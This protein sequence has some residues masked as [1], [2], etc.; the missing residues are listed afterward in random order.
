MSREP[1]HIRGL[2]L[3]GSGLAFLGDRINSIRQGY[4]DNGPVFT[5]SLGPKKLAVVIG[6]ELATEYFSKPGDVLSMSLATKAMWPVM[7]EI[8]FSDDRASHR[9]LLDAYMPLVSKSV[10]DQH[11]SVMIEEVNRSL[12]SFGDTG[13]FELV[14]ISERLS[15]AITIRCFLGDQFAQEAGERFREAFTDLINGIDM[16]LPPFLPLPKFRRRDRAR[17]YIDALI[18]GVVQR[19]RTMADPPADAMQW[20]ST[21]RE[22][23]GEFW[24]I[25]DTVDVIVSLL[26]G[27]HHITGALMSWALV[28][29][30]HYPE[31]CARVRDEVDALPELSVERIG[32][33]NY[34]AAAV[35]ESGRFEP[36]VSFIVRVARRDFTLGG[37]RIRK[38]WIVAL[39]PPVA[40]RMP[41]VFEEPNR[42]DPERFVHHESPA[43]HTLIGFGGGM[44]SCIG[45]T[46]ALLI[47]RVFVATLMRSYDLELPAPVPTVNPREMLRRPAFPCFLAY[48]SR[49][50]LRDGAVP[51][52]AGPRDHGAARE[53]HE[54]HE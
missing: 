44:H 26:F 18:E 43:R 14:T 49:G 40:Q 37:Y 19:R 21:L 38:G 39:C 10:L 42:Y 6:P 29:V 36:P 25:K 17:R 52:A 15:L 3:V 2:P 32:E 7:G 31:V 54:S 24:S 9:R 20:F 34:L 41:E 51:R 48:R 8:A 46:M 47:S 13:C 11:T 22:A 50:A 33:L 27:G 5:L 53:M 30:L 45:R 35:L 1:P 4:A 16:F 12:E 28:H 23:N